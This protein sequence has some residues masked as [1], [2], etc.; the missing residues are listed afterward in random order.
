MKSPSKSGPG[1]SV[2]GDVSDQ[3]VLSF[4][5]THVHE[6]KDHHVLSPGTSVL[7]WWAAGVQE[8]VG[9]QI[10][11]GMYPGA[12]PGGGAFHQASRML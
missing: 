4:R 6:S 1:D 3:G 7:G 11:T 5:T 8:G 12:P 9:T 10:A 2:N